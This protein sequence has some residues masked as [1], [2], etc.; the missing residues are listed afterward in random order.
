MQ[1]GISYAF[2]AVC[3]LPTCAI[4][5]LLAAMLRDGCASAVYL[6]TTVVI[7][8]NCSHLSSH[9]TGLTP[10]NWLPFVSASHCRAHLSATIKP[11][12]PRRSPSSASPLL[13]ACQHFP[14]LVHRLITH[15]SLLDLHQRRLLN[16]PFPPPFTQILHFLFFTGNFF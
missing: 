10:F 7:Y 6:I 8:F 12:L 4:S 13:L 11:L 1:L 5:C 15:S 2:A 3:F 14:W 9:S 16:S